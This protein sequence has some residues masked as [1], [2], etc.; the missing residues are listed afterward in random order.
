M[1]VVLFCY[2]TTARADVLAYSLIFGIKILATQFHFKQ[3]IYPEKTDNILWCQLWF[4]SKMTSEKQA[5]KFHT[6]DV[7]LPRS[8]ELFWLVGN[9]LHPN[10][11]ITNIWVVFLR[12]HLVEKPPMASKNVGRFLGLQ[13]KHMLL[14]NYGAFK[15]IILIIYWN[16][17][18]TFSNR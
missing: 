4:L 18:D 8:G 16:F 3:H 2:L 17:T 15:T 12:H 5:E 14:R 10:R 11:N 6:D 13:L 7:P 1:A 9:L